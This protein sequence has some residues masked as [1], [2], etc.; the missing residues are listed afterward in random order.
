MEHQD[1]TVDVSGLIFGGA[2]TAAY[3]PVRAR[4]TSL[5]R[6][7][8]AGRDRH[9]AVWTGQ[10]MLIFGGCRGSRHHRDGALYSPR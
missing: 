6:A 8:V 2:R 9:A 4:W 1:G 10:A 3:D 7:P 5:P